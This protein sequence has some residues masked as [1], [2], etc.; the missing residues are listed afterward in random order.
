M[1]S[2]ERE[3]TKSG[4]SDSQLPRGRET[5]IQEGVADVVMEAVLGTDKLRSWKDCLV[6]TG[7][8][9][10]D[11]AETHY[12]H[13]QDICQKSTI[14]QQVMKGSIAEKEEFR[15]PGLYQGQVAPRLTLTP[16]VYE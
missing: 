1:E 12:G 15:R 4:R 9:A 14:E 10:N 6:G 13:T 16:M 2:E 11:K 8:R 7:L 5:N 3:K